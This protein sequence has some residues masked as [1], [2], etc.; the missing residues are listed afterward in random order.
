MR[1]LFLVF[2]LLFGVTT[3]ASAHVRLVH[4]SPAE[5]QEFDRPIESVELRFS[6]PARIT[7]IAILNS[8]GDEFEIDDFPNENVDEATLTLRTPLLTGSYRLTWR[9]MSK[10]M[11]A[12]SGTISF[13]VK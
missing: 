1:S 5:G 8:S 7:S 10:D 11:H 13:T 4:S 12:M 9:G 3:T 6:E 2:I